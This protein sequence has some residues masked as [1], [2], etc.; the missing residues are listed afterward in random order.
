MKAIVHVALKN[1]VLDP[2]GKAVADT[3]ARMGY[4]EVEGARIG[5]VIE[6]DLEDGLSEADANTRVKEMCEK[7]L[8]NTVIES[9]RIDLQG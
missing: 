6:L 3:L 1:G 7:L 4:K 8:A 9:Y 5:K 2:Q